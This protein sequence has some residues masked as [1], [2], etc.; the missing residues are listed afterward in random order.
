MKGL[1]DIGSGDLADPEPVTRR[2][3]LLAQ[4][5][6]VVAVDF[7]QR[8]IADDVDIGL[9]DSLEHGGFDPEGLGPRRLH[10]IDRLTRLRLG[11]AAAIDRLGDIEI[12]RAA[13]IAEELRRRRG[14]ANIRC[15][16]PDAVVPRLAGDG[17]CRPPIR[18]GLRHRLVGGA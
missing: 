8:L 4:H 5:L 18:Q 13:D 12:D 2:F 7:D 15:L 10:G 14:A 3:K 6:F 11:A 9:R 17:D 16:D 1:R